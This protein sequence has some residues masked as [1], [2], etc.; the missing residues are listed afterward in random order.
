ME[1][2]KKQLGRMILVNFLKNH[3]LY[4]KKLE[5][6]RKKDGLKEEMVIYGRM[7]NDFLHKKITKI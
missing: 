3:L 5:Q 1:D 7:E 4:G 6:F 2:L